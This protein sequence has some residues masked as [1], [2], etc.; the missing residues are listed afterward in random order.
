MRKCL[1]LFSYATDGGAGSRFDVLHRSTRSDRSGSFLSMQ[2]MA[3]PHLIDRVKQR[4]T[5]KGFYAPLDIEMCEEDF[6]DLRNL[7]YAG[8]SANEDYVKC[9][10]GRQLEHLNLIYAD[11]INKT[12][13]FKNPITIKIKTL[14]KDFVSHGSVNYRF[15]GETKFRG[16]PKDKSWGYE[17]DEDGELIYVLDYELVTPQ[18]ALCNEI[19]NHPNRVK[20][21]PPYCREKI[22]KINTYLK[23]M[24]TF[25]ALGLR[26]GDNYLV[27]SRP[28]H[29]SRTRCKFRDYDQFISVTKQLNTLERKSGYSL[30]QFFIN[31]DDGTCRDRDM[32]ALVD[33]LLYE[34]CT[35]IIAAM[36]G[37]NTDLRQHKPMHP[38][39]QMLQAA[40]LK[41][42]SALKTPSVTWNEYEEIDSDED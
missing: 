36:P 29:F 20:M 1:N 23:S 31:T 15:N 40:K 21:L 11:H 19:Q 7:E 5:Y 17:L 22:L 24:E 33:K 27:V 42:K 16:Y 6:D 28:P 32:Y 10:Q 3:R 35:N 26:P 12:M 34:G 41:L 13:P 25:K 30:E 37:Y 18:D 8:I 4:N 2:G 38:R 9:E 39:L 14:G